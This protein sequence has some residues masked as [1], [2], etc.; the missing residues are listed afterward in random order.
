MSREKSC[1][2]RNER[3]FTIP[4]HGVTI[5]VVDREIDVA[6]TRFSVVYGDEQFAKPGTLPDQIAL[7]FAFDMVRTRNPNL[8][9]PA[10]FLGAWEIEREAVSMLAEMLHHPNYRTPEYDPQRDPVLGWFTDSGTSSFMQASWSLC[11]KFF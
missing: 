10:M 2:P 1:T 6:K 3:F 9:E 4:N 8:V 7:Q 11:N 5:A